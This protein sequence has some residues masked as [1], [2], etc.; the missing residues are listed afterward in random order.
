MPPVPATLTGL[1]G[2]YLWRGLDAEKGQIAPNPG[3]WY[4]ANDTMIV[5]HCFGT[6]EGWVSVFTASGSSGGGGSMPWVTSNNTE[7]WV[8]PGWASY[9]KCEIQTVAE[10]MYL[11]PIYC[12]DARTFKG[13]GIYVGWAVADK[14]TRLGIYKADP[15]SH[16]HPGDLVLDAGTVDIGSTGAKSIVIDETLSSGYYY[17]AVVSSGNPRLKGIDPQQGWTTPMSGI[18]GEGHDGPALRN[19][20]YLDNQSGLADSGLPDPC[21]ALISD[22]MKYMAYATALL[23]EDY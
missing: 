13:I 2:C 16:Y 11:I 7:V 12:G 6:E 18:V 14:K 21:P 20:P 9:D 23:L 15:D 5:Y 1:A 3:D 4:V 10:H 22:K 17:L 8:L 19:I